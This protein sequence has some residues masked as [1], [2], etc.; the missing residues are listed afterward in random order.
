MK[1]LFLI[2]ASGFL[3]R[4]YFAIQGL[5]SKQGES[6]NALYGFI[7][8]LRL[9]EQFQPTHLVAIF[10]GPR[11]NEA[12]TKLYPEY[13]AHRT[14]TPPDLI[15][16]I[17]EAKRFCELMGISILDI[18]AVEAD[19][20]IAAVTSVGKKRREELSKSISAHKTKI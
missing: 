2:D 10:D 9:K 4:A 6:T 3:Y 11:S 18:P 16:Q 8:F 19:D 7:R 17:E 5:S 15:A 20:T 13:K 1:N 14:A 12:R